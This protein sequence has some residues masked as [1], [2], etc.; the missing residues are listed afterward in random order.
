MN[1]KKLIKQVNRVIKVHFSDFIGT[2]FF[3]SRAGNTYSKDSDYDLLLT[4]G[5]Q[6]DWQEKNK[7][8]DLIA[9][10]EL[11]EKIIIDIKAYHERDFKDRWTP[12]REKVLKEGIF[13]GAI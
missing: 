7:I 10:I 12:F 6:L 5:H 11:K 2:Y 3:G 1:A 13:Y 8:Y 4:F 9:D